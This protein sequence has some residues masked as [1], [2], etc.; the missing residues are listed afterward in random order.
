MNQTL[1]HNNI[2]NTLGAVQKNTNHGIYTVYLRED[3]ALSH[4][5][6][7]IIKVHAVDNVQ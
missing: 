3:W 2:W 7:N 4:A 5:H 1:S 6:W